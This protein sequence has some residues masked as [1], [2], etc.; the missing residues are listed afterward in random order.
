MR[1]RWVLI[2]LGIVLLCFAWAWLI[3]D[4]KV[5][6]STIVLGFAV[7]LA[8]TILAVAF[9]ERYIENILQTATV[10]KKLGSA[11]AFWD[12]PR[13]GKRWT[14]LFG[15]KA[16]VAGDPQLRLSYA[17]FR[18]FIRIN[19]AVRGLHGPQVDVELKHVSEVMDWSSLASE[20]LV[21]LGGIAKLAG[22]PSIFEAAGMSAVQKV[23]ESGAVIELS[24]E[25]G[26]VRRLATVTAGSTVARDYALVTRWT[27]AKRGSC[28]ITFSGGEGLGTEAAVSAML[29]SRLI[30]S[31]NFNFQ[32][33]FNHAVVAVDPLPHGDFDPME[34]KLELARAGSSEL[35]AESLTWLR[36]FLSTGRMA[37]PQP[38][39]GSETA[40]G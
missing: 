25:D 1:R 31:A 38:A 6:V 16:P 8:A 24:G 34:S 19:D 2:A 20:N 26:Q 22:L 15:G 7:N 14:I 21:A 28:L 37:T 10:R 29:D 27:D 5:A 3:D 30:D 39:A 23:A 9:L 35:T 4:L 32:H 40:A 11:A 12:V 17:T 18:S 33:N 36:N 13:P